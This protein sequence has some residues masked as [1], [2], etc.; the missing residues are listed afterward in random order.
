M[1]DTSRMDFQILFKLRKQNVLSTL[2][3]A[4]YGLE[5]VINRRNIL[6]KMAVFKKVMFMFE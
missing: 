2:C 6:K 1:A 3:F 5:I 4:Y